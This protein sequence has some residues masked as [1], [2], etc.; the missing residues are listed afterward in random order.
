M[1]ISLGE[2]FQKVTL[3]GGTFFSMWLVQ[4]LFEDKYP[5]LTWGYSWVKHH[6]KAYIV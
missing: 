5:M 6:T 3:R 1:A 4:T 2:E